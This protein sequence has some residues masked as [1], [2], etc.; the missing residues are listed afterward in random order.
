MSD[1]DRG[2]E[3][4][5]IRLELI[6]DL[7]PDT[8]SG[9]LRLVRRK[10][11][12]H[13]PDGSVSDPFVYDETDR[14]AI[15][16]VVIVPHFAGSR[17]ERRIY[18]R[19]SLRPPLYFRDRSRDPIALPDRKGSLWEVPAGLI[20]PD[21]QTPEG[22]RRA[23]SRELFE[24]AGFA[25]P[26]ERLVELGP[27][28]FPSPGVI[29]ERHFFFAAEVDPKTKGE[30]TLDGSALERFG[31]V[32]DVSLDDALARCR[33]GDLEDAKTE[34]ALRRLRERYP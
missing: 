30:P 10:L 26:P 13:Y 2:L 21:E 12:A 5:P 34:L 11:R 32:V 15:D 31:E 3:F 23:A 27:S 18:L 33:N 28:T 7:S 4:P 6:E 20:E 25:V 17:G 19:S 14:R 22:L 1:G 24:E 16:A 8:G 9:Y 29:S